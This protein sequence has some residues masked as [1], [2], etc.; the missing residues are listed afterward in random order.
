MEQ[1]VEPQ[2][3]ECVP[4]VSEGRDRRVIESLAGALR[5]G[6]GVRRVDIHT[7]P[8]H[9]RSVFT[10]LGP[11]AA[12]EAAALALAE[13]AVQAI[14][15]RTH[16][17]VH[18][19][20]GALDVLPF[21]PVRGMSMAEAA[22]VARRVG[23]AL[24]T[25]LDL[26]VFFY[27]EAALSP[28]RRSLAPLRRGGYE[29]LASKLA[30]PAWRPDAG[31][32]RLHPQ[33]GATAVGARGVL[34]AFNVWL[35]SNDLE[36]AR[37]IAR[38]VRESAG[39]LPAVQAIGVPLPRRGVVQVALNLLDYRRT[40]LPR[41]FDRVKSEAAARGVAVGRSELVGMAPREAFD[42]AAPE[43]LGLSDFTPDK[44][45]ETHLPRE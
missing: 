38:A 26:P 27:G 28:Q 25:K 40:S 2:I 37:A 16:R 44:F 24:G 10:V 29:G 9:H 33:G 12:V 8:D 39:G 19:R 34:V 17:G 22:T 6:G 42:G 43:S 30:D 35:D 15:M 5:S 3:L 32:A 4:N 45:L 18:P 13:A 1:T 11:P 7:D 14:D 23:Q 36:A 41:A 21:V 20:I 31:P